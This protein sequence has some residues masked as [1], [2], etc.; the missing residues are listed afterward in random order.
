MDVFS[1]KNYNWF[2][3]IIFSEIL[4]CCSSTILEYSRQKKYTTICIYVPVDTSYVSTGTDWHC[5]NGK[6]Q[7]LILSDMTFKRGDKG[8]SN[9]VWII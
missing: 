8:G 2:P 5:P 7:H 3:S 4:I 1:N 9:S 6:C